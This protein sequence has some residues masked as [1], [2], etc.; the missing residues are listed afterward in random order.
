MSRF[1]HVTKSTKTVNRAGGEAF[2]MSPK[3]ALVTHVLTSMVKD[4]FYRS[5]DEGISE[6]KELLAKNDPLF[7]AKTALFARREYGLRSVSHIVAAEIAKTVKGQQWTKN[8]FDK[9]VYRPDDMTEIL[10]LYWADSKNEPNALKKGFKKAF[11]RFDGYQLAKYRGEGKEVSLVDVVNVVHPLHTEALA[12]LV[13]GEL[14]N[15]KTWEAK[16]SAT[17][18]DE[19]KKQE[20]WGDMLRSGTLGYFALLRNLRNILE[21]D[22]GLVEMVAAQLTDEKK[23][24][25]S[26]VM[27]FRFL[28]AMTAV[29]EAGLDT[30]A[31]RKIMS[32]ISQAMEIALSNVPRFE[33]KTLIVLDV[34]GSMLGNSYFGYS[35]QVKVP[36]DS[37]L[38]IGALFAAALYKTNEADM[39]LFTDDAEYR[40]IDPSYPLAAVYGE[41]TK[42]L[43]PSGTNFHAPFQTANK[44]YDRIIILSDSQ[45]WMG[46]DSPTRSFAQYKARTGASPKVFMFD[47]AGQGT[48]QLPE[49][50]VY[51]LAGFSDKTLDVLKLLE[52]DKSALI[53]TI[54]GVEI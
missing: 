52:T 28:S 8:F 13:K 40:A 46:Y 3:L 45:G 29:S 32:A 54:E 38:A 20:A 25:K 6:L 35:S 21:S 37:P 24:K 34:S 17:K 27:P 15:E 49:R 53:K 11:S 43:T 30:M 1:N 41:I 48:L 23:I 14:K 26:L 31:T 5:A 22:P 33:G 16:I 2:E 4:Q 50:D 47:L 36:H 12:K 9:I 10:S 44:A 19:T 7:A 39:M 42:N 18:G 51:C